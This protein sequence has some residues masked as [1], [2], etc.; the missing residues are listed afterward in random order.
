MRLPAEL[1]EHVLAEP[2][3]A[4][5]GAALRNQCEAIAEAVK[6]AWAGDGRQMRSAEGLRMAKSEDEK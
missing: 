6:E 3:L 1:R 4:Q 5:E 2:P